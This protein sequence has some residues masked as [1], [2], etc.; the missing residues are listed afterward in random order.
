MKKVFLVAAI[1]A[2]SMGVQAQ[3]QFGIQAG[4]NMGNVKSEYEYMGVTED[5]DNKSKIGFL[6]GG[7]AEIPVS[8]NFTFR[9]E[10]NFIQKGYKNDESEAGYSYEEK[11]TASFIE[12][13]L[14]FVYNATA[15][16]GTFFIGAGPNIGFGIGGKIEAEETY[17]GET[18]T[19]EVDIKFDGEES[20]TD[21]KVHLKALDFGANIIAGYKMSNGLFFSAGYTM[22]FSN[23]SPMEN[24]TFKTNG[25]QVKIG[26]MFGGAKTNGSDN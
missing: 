5:S 4:I 12:L 16:T 3:V 9:P 26:Y 11:A 6:I 10:L 13:P 22:G 17:A 14:N 18:E 24:Y 19:S 2:A 15:G 7:V 25:L 21:G 1:A 8:T 23:L 20:P